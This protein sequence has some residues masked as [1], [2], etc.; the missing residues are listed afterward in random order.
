[1]GYSTCP[2]PLLFP[3]GLFSQ[4]SPRTSELPNLGVVSHSLSCSPGDTWACEP[5]S[6]L[7]IPSL[8]SSQSQPIPAL[9]L[10]SQHFPLWCGIGGFS[11]STHCLNVGVSPLSVWL[12]AMWPQMS[13]LDSVCLGF[14]ISKLEVVI[15]LPLR[16]RWASPWDVTSTQSQLTINISY[17]CYH[18]LLCCK[19]PLNLVAFT[20]LRISQFICGPDFPRITSLCF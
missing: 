7:N 1:M 17:C 6:F 20:V 19:F 10:T 18:H 11:L 4:R 9:A 16:I 13:Y 5:L 8:L 15:F 3:T 14:F 12:L 2:I